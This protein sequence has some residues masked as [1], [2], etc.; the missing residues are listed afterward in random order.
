ML[1]NYLLNNNI[2]NI[3]F[4]YIGH[5]NKIME[6]IEIENANITSCRH[7]QPTIKI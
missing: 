1:M 2:N 3:K 7:Q 6:N 5:E 4:I